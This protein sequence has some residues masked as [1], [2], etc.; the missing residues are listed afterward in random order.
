MKSLKPVIDLLLEFLRVDGRGRGWLP[1]RINQSINWDLL[2]QQADRHGIIP[3]VYWALKDREPLKIPPSVFKEFQTFFQMN[4]RRNLLALQELLRVTALLKGRQ[5]E[6]LSFKGPVL[7]S[8]LYENPTL[9]YYVDL[10]FLVHPRDVLKIAAILEAD[11]YRPE[12]PLT[13]AAQG[14][15]LLRSNY[16]FNFFRDDPRIA[17]DVHW[18]LV[19][20]WFSDPSEEADWWDRAIE[21]PIGGQ[22]V[23]TLSPEDLL[24]I[25]C[26]HGAKH[27]WSK[28]KWGSDLARLIALKALDWPYVLSQ[29]ASR[30]S[31][32]LVHLGLLLAADLFKAPVPT[33]LLAIAR[34]DASLEAL[35]RR[36]RASF[37]SETR[38]NRRA[39]YVIWVKSKDTFAGGFQDI[40]RFIFSPQVID[41]PA[42][43]I[44]SRLPFF[45]YLPRPIALFRI[46]LRSIKRNLSFWGQ[47]FHSAAQPQLNPKSGR[48]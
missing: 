48:R 38:M 42:F 44:K 29:A 21:I 7:T 19:N 34:Q 1:S 4:A 36:V 2:F 37:N 28:M 15:F 41:W 17:I 6:V 27:G 40:L 32:R 25:L 14:T 31:R 30:K 33:S 5:I 26:I 13:S 46:G 9:R 20:R 18:G 39:L 10:D 8:I 22:K 35:V 45:N 24:V 43:T 47:G 23:R 12:M 11:G 16:E 3:Q